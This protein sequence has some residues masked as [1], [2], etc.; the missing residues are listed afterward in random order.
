MIFFA[1]HFKFIW[2]HLKEKEQK[3]V[4]LVAKY[5]GSVAGYVNL[6]FHAGGPFQDTEV[7][8]ECM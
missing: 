3:A 5:Q 8:R 2:N 6:Y 4:A 1:V 7:R